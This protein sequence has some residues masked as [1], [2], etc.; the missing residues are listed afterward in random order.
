LLI[1]FPN[2]AIRAEF[3]ERARL[4]RRFGAVTAARIG[5]RLQ[6]LFAARHLGD[7]PIDPPIRL[8][9]VDVETAEFAVAL[10]GSKRLRFQAMDGYS[11]TEGSIDF[12]TVKAIEVLG[13]YDR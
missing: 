1:C 7:V 9:I 13:V 10:G 11:L 6:V 4:E 12:E 2:S 3:N 8:R 5:T